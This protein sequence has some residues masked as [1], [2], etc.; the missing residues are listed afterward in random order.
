MKM[1]ERAAVLK[2]YINKSPKQQIVQE[3]SLLSFIN[4]QFQ[5]IPRFYD[6]FSPRTNEIVGTNQERFLIMVEAYL[7]FMSHLEAAVRLRDSRIA[8]SSILG[9][10]FKYVDGGFT[11]AQAIQLCLFSGH[12][13][14]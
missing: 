1:E 14:I 9:R 13:L 7:Y 11:V 8:L 12:N 2:K 3:A 6:G 5:E 10:V 4:Q